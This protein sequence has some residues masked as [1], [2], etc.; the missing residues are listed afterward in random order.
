LPNKKTKPKISDTRKFLAG[1]I[2]VLIIF[3]GFDLL[4][5]L[6]DLPIDAINPH[7][8]LK[9]EMTYSQFYIEYPPNAL[10]VSLY[11]NG[12]QTTDVMFTIQA[13]IVYNSTLVVGDPVFLKTVGAIFPKGQ[14]V[15]NQVLFGYDGASDYS[16]IQTNIVTQFAVDLEKHNQYYRRF[17]VPDVKNLTG[18][19]V[20]KWTTTGEYYPYAQ[21]IF[22]NGTL[23]KYPL[24]VGK[25]YV[26]GIET[27][28]QM[29]N[30]LQQADS[31]RRTIWIA[32]DIF[33]IPV[34][35][36]I[37]AFILRIKIKDYI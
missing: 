25:V 28:Q 1:I 8:T 14:Q 22:K 35:A 31:N 37:T 12:T 23:L 13:T 3:V 19:N 17:Y 24:S 27:L 9:S 29:E 15:I 33:L 4:T 21:V 11:K 26:N 10:E 5:N 36:G 2:I 20:I 16:T 32:V 30:N 18:Y 34:M 7:S 6:F